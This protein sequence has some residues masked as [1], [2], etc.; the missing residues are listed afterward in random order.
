MEFELREK[1]DQIIEK[2]EKIEKLLED[3][4]VVPVW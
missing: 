2:V 4:E 3:K 1:L